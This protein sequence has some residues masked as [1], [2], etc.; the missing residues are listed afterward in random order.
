MKLKSISVFLLTILLTG[1]TFAQKRPGW[2]FGMTLGD[3]TGFTV[4]Y[5][6]TKYNSWNFTLGSSYFG[7]LRL[8]ADY[9]WHF[10]PFN[11]NNVIMHVG[12]G[13][14]IGFGESHSIVF[15]NS[16][17]HFYLHEDETG[18]GIR[19]VVG[20]DYYP[21]SSPLEIFIEMGPLLG[22]VPRAGSAFDVAMGLRYYP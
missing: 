10:N 15:Y 7:G 5:N 19:G 18:I 12:F 11:S 1:A 4:K 22:L 14:V 21:V 6:S 8:G 2:G 20:I 16:N 9:L 13:G 3:P 17:R